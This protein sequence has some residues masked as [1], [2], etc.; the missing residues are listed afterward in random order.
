MIKPPNTARR[1]HGLL[2]TGFGALVALI[3]AGITDM[4]YVPTPMTATALQTADSSAAAEHAAKIDGIFKDMGVTPASDSA[5]NLDYRQHG[6]ERIAA[7]R[8]HPPRDAPSLGICADGAKGEDCRVAQYFWVT[9]D[10]P[11]AHRGDIE[12]VRN[13]AF[14]L[15]TSCDGAIFPKHVQ[16]CAWRMMVINSGAVVVDDTDT[17]NAQNECGQLNQAG[18]YAAVSRALQIGDHMPRLYEPE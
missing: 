17:A 6:A 4:H 1:R 3:G 12:A 13:V 7:Y 14:C 5:D 8:D 18:R 9:R 11:Q 15:S 16:G 2:A 10:W